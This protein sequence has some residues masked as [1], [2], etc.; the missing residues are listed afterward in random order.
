M[1]EGTS[2]IFLY[3]IGCLPICTEVGPQVDNVICEEE[4]P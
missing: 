1:F 3:E 2:Y 4:D